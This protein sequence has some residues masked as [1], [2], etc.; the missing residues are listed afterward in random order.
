LEAG[1]LLAH[2]KEAVGELQGA[3]SRCAQNGLVHGLLLC[4]VI[5]ALA[6]LN[7]RLF[8]VGVCT[9]PIA[10]YLLKVSW[11]RLARR[12]D[13]ELFAGEKLHQYLYQVIPSWRDVLMSCAGGQ[14]QEYLRAR[15][16]DDRDAK[17][18]A[19]NARVTL[20]PLVM[21]VLEFP[22]FLVW[23]IGTLEVSAE[24]LTV[25]ELVTFVMYLQF[26]Y[27]PMQQLT[28]LQDDAARAA[29]AGRRLAKALGSNSLVLPRV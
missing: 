4:T 21:L 25:G 13:R 12:S 8:V 10:V 14:E 26:L 9:G 17:T 1:G 23:L 20:F 18:R 2:F 24:R 15:L 22:V 11:R 28:Q 16:A 6:V 29:A 19:Q 27:A 5:S 3:L 7:L